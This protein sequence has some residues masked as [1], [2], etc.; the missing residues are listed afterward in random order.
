MDYLIRPFLPWP[1][2]LRVCR[3][4]RKVKFSLQAGDQDMQK[5]LPLLFGSNFPGV[6]LFERQRFEAVIWFSF[7]LAGRW[8]HDR[9]MEAYQPVTCGMS[10][11]P[12]QSAPICHGQQFPKTMKEYDVQHT[13]VHTGRS[14][15]RQPVAAMSLRALP[16]TLATSPVRP[17][18]AS[19]Q[20]EYEHAHMQH[21]GWNE[22]ATRSIREGNG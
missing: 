20:F 21:N 11:F 8:F 22:Y 5:I 4:L 17:M 13:R 10:S 16:S 7:D 2:S 1:G 6:V 19:A 18:C 3:R 14:H 9:N 15:K 12:A